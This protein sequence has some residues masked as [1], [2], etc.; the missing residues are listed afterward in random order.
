[1]CV[2]KTR[3]ELILGVASV[4]LSVLV[5]GEIIHAAGVVVNDAVVSKLER[6]EFSDGCAIRYPLPTGVTTVLCERTE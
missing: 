3:K 1:M 5:H 2:F 4:G 6:R